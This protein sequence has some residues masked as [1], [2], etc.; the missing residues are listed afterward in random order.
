M[1]IRKSVVSVLSIFLIILSA[2]SAF[3]LSEAEKTFLSM[4]FSESELQIVSTTRS[5]KSITRVAENVEVVTKADIELMNAHTVADVLNRITGV[6]V[7]N[8]GGTGAFSYAHI[9]GSGHNHIAVFMDGLRVNLLN[10]DIADIGMIPAQLVEK[11]EVIKGPASSVWGSSLGGVINIITK[12]G[13]DQMRSGGT[14]SGNMGEQTFL[15]ARAELYG[16]KDKTGY[17]FYAGRMQSDGFRGTPPNNAV[18]F[19]NL[20]MKLSQDLG[21]SS[22]IVL[23]TF[24]DRGSRGSG[25]PALDWLDNV[26]IENLF[27]TLTFNTSL[28]KGVDLSLSARTATRNW[29]FRE[30]TPSTE[31]LYDFRSR[32]SSSGASAKVSWNIDNHAVVAGFDYDDNLMKYYDT[33]GVDVRGRNAK[34]ALFINDTI[35]IGKF[36]V[37]PG[38]RY[39]NADRVK[40]FISP[41]LGVTYELG[42]QTLLRA[43]VSRGFNEPLIVMTKDN[44][45]Y[46][47]IGNPGIK[48][49]K[50]WSY[51]AGIETGAL[52][53]FWLKASAFRHDISDAIVQVFQFDPVFSYMDVNQDRV[54]RQGI[55][56]EIRTLPFYNF[57]LSAGVAAIQNKNRDTGDV[58]RE[59]PKYTYDASL[60]YDDKKTLRGLLSAHYIWFDSTSGGTYNAWVVDLNLIKKIYKQEDREAELFMTGHNLFD[61]YQHA[62][63]NYFNAQRWFE[64][65]IR[66]KF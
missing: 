59:L 13:A 21:N 17:Y 1:G 42:E 10:T 40:D 35:K 9:Q 52:K 53:Y 2:V 54:R 31:A 19:S 64:A 47:Y 16:K 32:D 65:G 8:D 28:A 3:G 39:D 45:V 63:K 14:L 38:I 49:E 37:T 60:K 4:Y 55:E 30:K 56:T 46:G 58:V 51:Q 7:R 25:Y 29:K 24:Y 44:P 15:D 41:S 6:Q 5:L 27:A 18:A 26:N 12:S 20:Y 62:S 11:I 43:T 36:S 50:V 48:P 34:T 66:F 57:T 61:G 22:Q 33:N 23:T